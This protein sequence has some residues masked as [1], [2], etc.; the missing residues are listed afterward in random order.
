MIG[1]E[2]GLLAWPEMRLL[3]FVLPDP[4]LILV[5]MPVSGVTHRHRIY[6]LG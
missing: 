3:L 4:F 1:F 5:K 2:L 6:H